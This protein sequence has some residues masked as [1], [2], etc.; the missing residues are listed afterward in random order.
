MLTVVLDFITCRLSYNAAEKL[1]SLDKKRL[2]I[3]RWHLFLYFEGWEWSSSVPTLKRLASIIYKVLEMQNNSKSPPPYSSF[4]S[5]VVRTFNAP[6]SQL[7]LL[8]PTKRFQAKVCPR[9]AYTPCKK[10]IDHNHWK[11]NLKEIYIAYPSGTY[12]RARTPRDLSILKPKQLNFDCGHRKQINKINM[13][14][15]MVIYCPNLQSSI[16]LFFLIIFQN[17]PGEYS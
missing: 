17:W 3:A 4:L 8:I 13:V 12:A 11:L 9:C 14:C 5:C 2:Y 15:Y 7:E 10:V 6:D 16:I 1:V